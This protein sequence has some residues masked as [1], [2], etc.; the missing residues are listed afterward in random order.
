MTVIEQM[1]FTS[2]HTMPLSDGLSR[3]TGVSNDL[4][5]SGHYAVFLTFEDPLHTAHLQYGNV[6]FRACTQ[7]REPLCI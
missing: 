4:T 3:D 5:T 6:S 2:E 1:D 7:H